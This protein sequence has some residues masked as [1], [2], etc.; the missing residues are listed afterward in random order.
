MTGRI[1]V[2]VVGFGYFGAFHARHYAANPD[3]DLVA[4]ADP[5]ESRGEV[6]RSTYGD[7]HKTV[8]ADLVGMVDAVS[9]AAPTAL[10]DRIAPF[11]IDAGIHV[12]VEKPLA[13]TA[14]SAR[15]LAARAE[16]AG[17]VLHVGHVERFSPAYRAL[18]NAVSEPR[19]IECRRHS[20]W[21]GRVIDVD[22]VLDLMIHDIDL[23]LDLARSPAVDVHATGM[24]LMG[25]GLDAVIA[26]IGFE[27]GAAAHLSASR[28]AASPG[29]AITVVEAGRSYM[30]DLTT[31]TLSTFT[32]E[33]H[34]QQSVDV[35]AADSL[36]LEIAAFL[37]AVAGGENRG[38]GGGAAVAA[39]MV[40]E[41]IRDAA[42][43]NPSSAL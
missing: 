42:S 28:V 13:A 43:R 40:A 34:G 30:V 26:R 36:G 31:R 35:P 2:G 18:R 15:Y 7:I 4:I 6:I 12:L 22:V 23:A 32:A 8:Y 9:I 17:I 1:R 38:V 25:H 21:T 20:A 37:A 27:N 16:H 19:L 29:R 24:S 41:A 11:F 5:S 10:H 33:G 3:A 39:L 14:D